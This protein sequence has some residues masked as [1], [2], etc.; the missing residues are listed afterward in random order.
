MKQ[1]IITR[2]GKAEVHQ[3]SKTDFERN[4]AKRGKIEA[5]LI[6]EK[7]KD[8]GVNPNAFI[9]S[10]ANRAFQT[11]KKFAKVFGYPEDQIITRDFLYGHY[12]IDKIIYLIEEMAMDAQSVILFGHNPT[13]E[14]LAYSLSNFNDFYQQVVVLVLSL[15]L[16]PGVK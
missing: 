6:A 5:P 8:L 12:S 4:L 9:S 16:I 3:Y 7:I 10:P 2:H 14:E 13:L 11:S 1:I 15:M